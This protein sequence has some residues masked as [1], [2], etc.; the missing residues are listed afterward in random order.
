[1][2]G[3]IISIVDNIVT[4]K[5]SI[6]VDNQV[7]LINLHAVLE[8]GDTKIVGEI[9]EI[10]QVNAKIT[11]VGEI[12]GDAFLPGF[13]KKPSF[14]SSVRLVKQEEL[15]LILGKT[16]TGKNEFY[17]GLSSVYQNYRI[18]VGINSFF[19]SHFAILGNTGSGKSFTVSRLLQNIFSNPQAL[20]IS[21]NI[22][23]FDAYG[24][25]TN[26][27]QNISQKTPQIHYKNYTTNTSY[28]E[29]EILRIPLWLLG[30][31]DIAQLLGVTTA[32]QLPIIDKAL[33]LVTI[34]KDTS[35]S[36]V[37]HKNNIISRALMDIL[38][39]GKE[40]VKIRDQVTAVL[41]NF[42]TNELNLESQIVQPGYTRTLK[43]C[44]FVD[45]SGKMQEMET[46][47]DF[48]RQFMTEDLELKKPDGSVPYTLKDLQNALD[49]AL[50]SEGV[51][52][53]DKVF[54]YANILSVRLRSLVNS[55]AAQYFAY[56]K[57]ISRDGFI[58]KLVQ[59]GTGEKAQIVNFNINYVDDRM[60][61]AITKILSKLL[62]DYAVE[63]KQRAAM[64]FHI[65]IEEAHRYVQ[66]D[67]DEEILGYNIFDRIT[68]EGRKYGVLLGLITQRPSELSETSISQC[69]NFVILRTLHPKDLDYIRNM[70]PNMSSAIIEHLKTLQ[71]GHCIAFGS[72]FKVPISM[73]V[74][75][76]NPEPLSNSANIE[77]V[78]FEKHEMPVANDNQASSTFGSPMNAAPATGV[79]VGSSN[80]VGTGVP[81]GSSNPVGR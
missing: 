26:A 76:P 59:S 3:K 28:P 70:V 25:Y 68:K 8:D 40:S 10:D 27:F 66:H 71:P 36:V 2:L 49:F 60:A 14:R 53:S 17:F 62:F 6:N 18:S 65:I 74:E 57:M 46:V 12:V 43:Q 22:F 67:Q 78:W 75:R 44:L 19:S 42:N 16:T 51:L 77:K 61:K 39:S 24:E 33:Q 45:N 30:T 58:H 55:E 35:E 31:D 37:K 50:I 69:S 13:T 52:Q 54:D 7:N 4:I 11:I 38:V 73:H 72:A 15:A 63:S 20:P 23:I 79:A 48:V 21:A 32:N 29:G 47:V 34:L 64:P 9:E 1:M 41:T 56:P 81:V 5:L 80:P